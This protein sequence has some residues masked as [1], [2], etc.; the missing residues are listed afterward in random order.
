[1]PL[2]TLQLNYFKRLK[3]SKDLTL[4][5]TFGG[6]GDIWWGGT[7]WRNLQLGQEGEEV[8]SMTRR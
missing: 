8:E 4:V 2:S 7:E 5:L 1:M 6:G 3:V